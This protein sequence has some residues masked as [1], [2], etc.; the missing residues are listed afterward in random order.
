MIDEH[1]LFTKS[2][3]DYN[4]DCELSSLYYICK[5]LVLWVYEYIFINALHSLIASFILKFWFISSIFVR[6]RKYPQKSRS[7]ELP[8]SWWVIKT[9]IENKSKG[10]TLGYIP[11]RNGP[12]VK[13]PHWLNH[14]Q[15]NRPVLQGPRHIVPGRNAFFDVTLASVD[16][17]P[18]LRKEARTERLL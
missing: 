7:L 5:N 1:R 16:F 6:L 11:G 10:N 9:D 4:R 17:S 18:L 12:A 2:G 15:M 8:F 3:R 13:R 14:P